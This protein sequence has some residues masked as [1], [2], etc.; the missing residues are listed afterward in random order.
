MGT[1]LVGRYLKDNH[2]QYGLYL[3]GWFNCDQWDTTDSR[4]KRSQSSDIN[5]ARSQFDEQASTLSQ[6]DVRIKA[7]VIN[8]ALH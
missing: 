2:C 6:Q 7:F 8:M 5:K 3:V 1:Q 4:K